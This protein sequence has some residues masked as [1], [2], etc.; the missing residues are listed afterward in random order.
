MGGQTL[1]EA[2]EGL[3]MRFVGADVVAGDGLQQGRKLDQIVGSLATFP[4]VEITQKRLRVV[5]LDEDV[6]ARDPVD[7][8][9]AGD[10]RRGEE[11]ET[12]APLPRCDR[13]QGSAPIVRKDVGR[14]PLR[15]VD[16]EVLPVG[17]W[18]VLLP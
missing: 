18:K 2:P 13:A 6:Q 3:Q 9:A 4:V 8:E 1:D 16:L 12:A 7:W 5:R 11:Q 14:R 17:G 15:Q 10:Q